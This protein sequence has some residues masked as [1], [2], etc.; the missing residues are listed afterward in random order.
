MCKKLFYHVL[1]DVSLLSQEKESDFC[2]NLNRDGFQFQIN[3]MPK[4]K[5]WKEKTIEDEHLKVLTMMIYS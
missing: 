4:L 5:I 3:Q 2:H 1:I